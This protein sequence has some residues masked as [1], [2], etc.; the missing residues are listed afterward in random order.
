MKHISGK[1]RLQSKQTVGKE[2]LKI[3]DADQHPKGESLP[4]AQRVY[5][6]K[7]VQTFLSAGVPLNKLSDFRELLEENAYKLTD[8]YHMSDIIPF[9]LSQEQVKIK[10]EISGRPLSITFDGTTIFGGIFA[11]IVCF[12]DSEV[13]IQ[14]RLIQLKLLAQNLCGT[15]M[16]RWFCETSGVCQIIK[17]PN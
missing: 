14:Q 6:I 11:V 10:D 8:R 1:K 7:V 15:G 13:S 12:I 16:K 9:I 4:E 2:A 5:C 3:H 17:K